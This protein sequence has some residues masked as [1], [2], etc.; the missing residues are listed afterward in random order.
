MLK[1]VEGRDAEGFSE[2]LRREKD[3]RRIC[4]FSPIFALL[5]LIRAREGKLL[6]YAQSVEP[7]AQSVVSFASLA[8]FA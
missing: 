6:R 7:N 5:H 3:R 4:G 1:F 8:F 2:F